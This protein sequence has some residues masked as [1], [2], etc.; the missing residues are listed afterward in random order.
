MLTHE[1]GQ[2]NAQI[3]AESA[4]G[5]FTYGRKDNLVNTY[6]L[7]QDTDGILQVRW[8]SDTSGW[9]GPQTYPALADADMGTD[10]TCLTQPAWDETKVTLSSATDMNR[11]YFQ[12]GGKVKEVR[13][14]GGDW[15]DL[16][17][18]PMP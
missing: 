8:Q 2:L 18:I 1:I 12:S 3:P 13:F 5:A 17:F 6:I 14:D 11:C 16:G 10:I 7:Y 15:K 4:I 9:M